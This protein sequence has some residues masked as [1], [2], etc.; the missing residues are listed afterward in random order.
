[1]E[2]VVVASPPFVILTSLLSLSSTVNAEISRLPRCR[3]GRISRD[4]M[5]REEEM[6]MMK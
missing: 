4:K 3:N 1:V 6:M 5:P 2:D